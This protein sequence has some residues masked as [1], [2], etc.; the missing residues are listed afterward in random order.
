V[1]PVSWESGEVDVVTVLAEEDD[2]AEAALPEDEEA[3]SA[4]VMG[5]GTHE[6]VEGSAKPLSKVAAAGAGAIPFAL[7]QS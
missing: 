5:A 1:E 2:E 7:Q 3:D 6:E 4:E